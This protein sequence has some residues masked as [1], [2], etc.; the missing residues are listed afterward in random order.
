MSLDILNLPAWAGSCPPTRF[1]FYAASRPATA[2]DSANG[3]TYATAQSSPPAGCLSSGVCY[4]PQGAEYSAA[5]GKTSSFAG[6]N[7]SETY[8]NRLQ[9]LE[10]KASSSSGNALDI[11][12]SFVDPSGG[13]AGHVNSITNNLNS[14]RTQS[15]SYDSLNRVVNA[16]TSATSGTFCFGYQY[17]YDAWGNLL[18]QA[19]W[20][21]N[22][23]GCSEATMGSV[24]ADGNNHISGFSYDA[25]GNTQNDGSIA[26][27]YNA[28]SQMATAAGVSYS[29]DAQG[30]RVS[31]SNGKNYVYGL[32]GEI[33]TETDG[34]GN[35]LNEYIFFAGRRVAI[36]PAGGSAEYYVEDLLGSSR[37]MTQNN[38]TV[39]YDADFDPYGGEHAYTNNCPSSS[40]Y[41]FEGKERDT[42]TGNDDFG[43]RYYSNRFGRWLSADWSNVPVPVP[44]ANLSNPQTLNLYS[45]VADDPE[46]FADLDGHCC[47]PYE[48]ADYLDT[49]INSAVNYVENKA[50][51]SGSPTLA[52]TATFAAGV[53]GDVGKGFTNL[54]RTGESVGSLPE[55]AS[56][57]QIATAIAEEG[58]RVGG[59]ILAVVAVAGPKTPATAE[60]GA[61]VR[62][63]TPGARV[64]LKDGSAVDLTGKDHGGVPTPHIKSLESNTNPATGVTYQKFGPVRPAT[65]GDVNAAAKTAG[66]TPPVRIPPPL[67]V[68]QPKKENQ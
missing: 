65:V 13:N 47:A 37:V 31:K 41:K 66:V 60:Q 51:A 5:I 36:L 39:C 8:N 20:S 6:V 19:G 56:G 48:L 57:G 43:A 52:A 26:Y 49:K 46:S 10:I 64:T 40:A 33:L 3:I 50:I 54:L 45:M 62:A 12:Y 30:R 9:P 35:T 55:N 68:P 67:P 11:T 27:T 42:E 28:E 21:P 58:G 7:V 34:S 14:S 63:G 16:G 15:F 25:S 59:T 53:T 23:N 61:S 22:Y 32:G 44:Y 2:T 29:Y 18:A 17:S 1:G 4:T 24:T 38:G